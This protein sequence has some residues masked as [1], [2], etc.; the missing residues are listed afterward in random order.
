VVN[1]TLDL[2]LLLQVSDGNPCKTAVNFQPLDEGGLGNHSE[3][4]NFLQ[5]TVIG[6]F[7]E[8]DDV[9]GLILDLSLGPFLL[10]RCFPS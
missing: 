8:G 1:N 2:A 5:Y 6:S 10:L 7:V 4:R 3:G 9:L